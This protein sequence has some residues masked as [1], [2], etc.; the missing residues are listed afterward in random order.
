MVGIKAGRGFNE[1]HTVDQF[2]LCGISPKTKL[3]FEEL[4]EQAIRIAALLHTDL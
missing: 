2:A 4:L 3:G 1:L